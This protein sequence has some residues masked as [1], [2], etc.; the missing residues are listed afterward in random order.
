MIPVSKKNSLKKI[1][2]NIIIYFFIIVVLIWILFPF[3]WA[4][5][6]S[7][8][9]P[10][11]WLTSKLIPFLEFKPTLTTWI[12]AISLPEVSQALINNIIIATSSA[13]LAII[14]GTPAAY[15]LARFEFKRWKNR[16]ISIFILS[17]RMLPPAVVIIPFF[18]MMHIS[19]LLD[20]QLSLIL[21]HTTFNLPFVVWI[22][23]EFFLDLPKQ[24]EEAALIDGCSSLIA[25][26]KIA[27]PLSM[28][29][30]I[31]TWILCFIF[32]WNEF[33]FVLILS[34]N[35][36]ITLPWIIA[37]GEH[38]RG[39]EW[40]LITTHTL[41]SIIPPIVMVQFIRK[42]LIRGLTLGMVK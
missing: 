8:K 6:T 30:L 14:L 13:T 2:E 3:Y 37:S 18:L 33:L 41:L 42:Y 22:I 38:T 40:G 16:D 9:A 39:I 21:V 17:Q 4:L 19:G 32:S 24:Y 10:A 7:I 36:S 12:E 35:K 1:A 23:R 20:T 11:D 15:A 5:V 25:F 29:G 27:L 26:A 28:Y 31:A 34:Y